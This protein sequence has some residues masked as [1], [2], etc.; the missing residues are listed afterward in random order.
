MFRV[1][2]IASVVSRLLPALVI[3]TCGSAWAATLENVRAA[4]NEESTPSW[5]YLH[6]LIIHFPIAL[7]L[8]SPLFILISTVPV[9]PRNK[10]YMIAAIVILL[11]GTSG[12]FLAGLTGHAAAEGAE[13]GRAVNTV[14]QAHQGLA[15][16]TQIVFA[17]LSV[18]LLG[19]Y[20]I[21][22]ALHCEENRL[23]ATFLPL[24][25]LALY[26]AGILFLA[27]TAHAGVQ[28]VHEFDVHAPAPASSHGS[29]HLRVPGDSTGTAANHSIGAYSQR[30][31]V[32]AYH[33]P[34]V[35]D[36]HTT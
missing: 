30:I 8:L 12:L 3:V 6:L 10:P 1:Q 16:E 25:F 19:I 28:L 33:F 14:L 31:E 23:F 34:K 35:L 4:Y 36:I 32:G 21:P 17:G 2:S 27:N 9:P 18:I 24:A 29:N 26:A 7:L 22:K 15:S 20:V 13:H 11:L 5:N